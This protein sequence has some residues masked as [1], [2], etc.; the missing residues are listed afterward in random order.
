MSEYITVVSRPLTTEEME[1]NA[2]YIYNYLGALGWTPNAVAGLLGNLQAESTINPGRYQGDDPSGSGWGL[3]QWTPHSKY[4]N[5]CDANGLVWY[6]M[7]S[8]LQ[9]LLYEMDNGI[10]F[11]KSAAYPITFKQFAVSDREP[12]WLGG[13]FL[14]N[15]EKPASVLYDPD[16]ET[17]EEH[18]AKRAATIKRRGN[19][20]NRWYEFLTG[21]PAP[22]MPGGKGNKRSM[23]LL[24]L[25]IATRRRSNNVV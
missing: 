14:C 5:W 8:A 3:A 4:T 12:Y 1:T 2:T 6:E 19:M 22:E 9:R 23:S 17:Y 15:Y 13:A 21:L 24:M 18:L 25:L 20:S 16:S 7:D 10:Q 11:Y